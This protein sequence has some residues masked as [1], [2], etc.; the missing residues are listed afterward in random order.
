[1]NKQFK[2][3]KKYKILSIAFIIMGII[4]P[5]EGISLLLFSS[6]IKIIPI[7]MILIGLINFFLSGNIK[8]EINVNDDYVDVKYSSFFRIMKKRLE[9]NDILAISNDNNGIQLHTKSGNIV[10]LYIDQAE[11]CAA[12]INNKI[13]TGEFESKEN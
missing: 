2:I 7:G 12:L 3:K 9:Y 4:I 10:V 1:M 5:A 13:S 6:I 8:N 11:E